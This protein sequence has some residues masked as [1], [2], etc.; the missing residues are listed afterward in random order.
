MPTKILAK[1]FLSLVPFKE[2]WILFGAQLP[3]SL[4]GNWLQ[5]LLNIFLGKTTQPSVL[6]TNLGI[7]KQ[8]R[9][10]VPSSVG[11]LL[12]FG[13]PKNHRAERG[14]LFLS[15]TLLDKSEG[16]LDIG[17]HRG[18]FIFFLAAHNPRSM[19]LHFFEPNPQ[20]FS[21]LSL[22]VRA[23]NLI[24]VFGHQLAIGKETAEAEFYI[25]SI[26]D[27]V[28]SLLSSC[29][30]PQRKVN[31]AVSTLDDFLSQSQLKELLVKVDI[32][33]AEFDFLEGASQEFSRVKF[34]IIEV[35]GPAI[36]K[37]F[38][39]EIQHRFKLHAYYIN[40]YQLE[41]SPD[42]NFRYSPPQYNWL[43]CRETPEQLSQ[44][45]KHSPLRVVSCK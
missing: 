40:D 3:P 41:Y 44:T 31:V 16:F 45:L 6:T 9:I 2:R 20:L 28:S 42:G 1:E 32:E 11:P 23:N 21:E 22:N 4:K 14:A 10:T 27:S 13:T 29:K 34:L 25:D 43:F 35:L 12:L 17:S 30:R 26:D 36:S 8:Y 7:S 39:R 38:I 24:H 19:P 5:R 33:N 18:Y 15:K 37:G